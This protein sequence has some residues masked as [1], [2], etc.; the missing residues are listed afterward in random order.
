MLILRGVIPTISISPRR[1]WI[2]LRRVSRRIQ[3]TTFLLIFGPQRLRPSTNSR[4]LWEC[5]TK[6]ESELSP[7]PMGQIL[8]GGAGIR[9]ASGAEIAGRVW[10]N[11]VASPASDNLESGGG[12]GRRR[13]VG[14]DRA[15][16][17]RGHGSSGRGS[18][19]GNSEPAENPFGSARWKNLLARSAFA[20]GTLPS[21]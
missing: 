20:A 1:S 19:A 3:V 17:A 15:W 8:A 11:A 9:F 18:F 14:D 12:P 16:K 21:K 10:A 13:P 6:L 4:S 7:E 2:G 5:A